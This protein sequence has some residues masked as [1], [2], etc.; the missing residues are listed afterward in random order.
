MVYT[1]KKN[2]TRSGKKKIVPDKLRMLGFR[3]YEFSRRSSYRR[4][5]IAEPAGED[6]HDGVILHLF[7]YISFRSVFNQTHGCCSS[8][9][10]VWIEVDSL[11]T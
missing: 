4:I 10:H 8:F 5:M 3:G 11:R 7:I 1:Y 6:A 9:G 2:G